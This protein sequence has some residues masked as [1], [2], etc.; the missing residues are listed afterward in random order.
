MIEL[1]KYAFPV[2]VSYAAV[3][4]LLGGLLIL[5]I[6]D[7]YNTRRAIRALEKDEK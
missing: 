2:L 4:V 3:A 7:Q 1:G 6:R 5:S